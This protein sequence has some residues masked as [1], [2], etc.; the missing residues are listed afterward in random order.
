MGVLVINSDEILQ[1]IDGIAA[2]ASKNEKQGMVEANLDDAGFKRVCEYA[3]NPFK[4]YGIAKM[5][6]RLL[7]GDEQF[8]ETT[9]LILDDLIERKL[10]GNDARE[11]IQ[12]IL[13]DLTEDSA[14]LFRRILRK[15]LRAGFS[16]STINKACKGL[17]PEFPYQRCCL[18][19]D[20]KLDKFDWETGVLS[21]EKAD[22]MF[23]NV[24]YDAAGFVNVT[25]RQGSPFPMEYFGA[26]ETAIKTTFDIGTQSHGEVLVMKDGVIC[27]R[28]IGNGI[29]NSVLSGSPFGVGESPIYLVWDQIP[30]A[31]VVKKG[32]CETSYV[33]RF[34]RLHRQIKTNPSDAVKLIPTRICHNMDAAM[35]HY[36]EMLA[37]GK[38]GTVI[39]NP[40]AIWKDGTSKDQ[41]KLKMEVDVDLEVC[42]VV[43][44]KEGGKN[45]GRPGSLTCA[46]SDG[47]LVVDVTVKNEA[48]RDAIEADEDDW[49]GR[50]IVVR[51]NQIMAPSESNER[52]SLFLPR[53][54]EH[55]YRTD[56]TEADSL[57]RVK[58]QFDSAMKGGK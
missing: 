22:G 43:E 25:S 13:G 32:K 17:I 45:E 54:V 4:T 58:A 14:E 50:I 1:E 16:E 5:P 57:E 48:M 28:E 27:A 12:D 24:N 51:F 7:D 41:V 52:H 8:S 6:E 56:K 31:S 29:L 46:T 23:A 2:T 40:S 35:K 19:K 18:P 11:A 55:G 39:K 20:T 53:M 15:D 44:G 38:E 10:T 42:G 33:K 9:W 36:G 34:A 49:I 26:L 47:L 30:M 37:A 21:Q 3:Y